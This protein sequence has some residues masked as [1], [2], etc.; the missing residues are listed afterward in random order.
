MRKFGHTGDN[1][2]AAAALRTPN[3]EIENNGRP[4]DSKP[5]D[6]YRGYY[7]CNVLIGDALFAAGYD[8]PLS[9]YKRYLQPGQLLS[10]LLHT[11]RYADPIWISPS[12]ADGKMPNKTPDGPSEDDLAKV[13]PG[14][15]ILLHAYAGRPGHS[16]IVTS[17]AVTDKNGRVFLRVVDIYGEQWYG[18]DGQGPAAIFRP[19]KRRWPPPMSVG[20]DPD[21]RKEFLDQNEPHA[22]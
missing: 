22:A 6:F 9:P 4:A 21:K 20:G 5:I 11:R 10:T 15:V 2:N 7:K 1:Y 12:Y 14:D 8:W 16:A 13:Q 19:N 3:P 18:M 17:G